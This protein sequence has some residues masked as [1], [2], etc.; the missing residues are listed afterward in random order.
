MQVSVE[1]PSNI[2]R[3]LTITVPAENVEKAFDKRI[4]KFSKTAKINGFRPGKVPMDVV[5][6]RYGD[7]AR[8]EALSE[9][10]QQT[11][12]TAMNQE[13]LS[14]VS[15]PMVE[16]KNIA[17]GAPLEFV[18][19]FDVLPQIEKVK[20]DLPTLEKE[21]ST[22]E[23][24]D[25]E[26]VLENLS[27]QRTTWKEVN[28]PAA[29]KDK[30]IVDFKGT[31]DGIPFEGADA[32]DFTIIL[33]S[34]SMVPGF[35]EGIVGAKPGD[36]RKVPVTF[37]EDYFAKEVAGKV[38]EFTIKLHKVFQPEIPAMDEALIKK[39]GIKSGDIKELK[40]EISRNLQ[41]ELTRIVQLKL[42]TNVF[43]KLVEQ[44]PVE[45]PQSLIENET[46][47]IH[48]QL[49]PHH[50]GHEHHHSE[51]EMAPFQ[52]MAQHN[53][54]LGLLIGALAKEHNVTADKEAV[55]TLV[56]TLASA[57]EDPQ[58]VIQWYMKDKAKRQEVEMQVLEDKILE[59]LLEKVKVKD[60]MLSYSEL[61][62][63]KMA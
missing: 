35:E 4:E 46:K 62:N 14:P 50:K 33:G 17:P 25:I 59:K 31:L 11:L 41:R 19:T 29:L 37:P 38:T 49:H 43:N 53:V 51:E 56:E 45:L 47:R 57:Y 26:R 42:K 44:N 40:D 55:K 63:S 15:V 3:R 58:S 8:E 23:N 27:A 61:M 32:H 39:L 12:Y 16:P 10:I 22:I 54:A 5:K 34:K 7:V 2:K 21:I 36:E 30:T 1:A 28:R 20:F 6:Q 13:K 48:D 9:V 52:K 24:A 60:K 18:A